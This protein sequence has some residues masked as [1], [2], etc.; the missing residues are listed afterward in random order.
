M[1][2]FDIFHASA[3]K[4]ENEQLKS[5]IAELQS[6][7]DNLK[8]NLK[9]LSDD[10]FQLKQNFDELQ[11]T[12]SGET[13]RKLQQDID[14]F[15]QQKNNALE[16]L[17]ATELLKQ[18]EKEKLQNELD[19]ISKSIIIEQEKYDKKIDSAKLKVKSINT[20][21]K[22]IQK[23]IDADRDNRY[24]TYNLV[25]EATSLVKEIDELQINSLDV[26]ALRKLISNN[27]ESVKNVIDKYEN[28][29]TTKSNKAVYQLMVLALE[30]ELQNVLLNLKLGK[31]DDAKNKIK[32]LLE[33]YYN[34]SSN[35]NQSIAPTIKKF[36]LEMETLYIEAIEIEYEYYTQKERIKEEQRAIKEQMRQEAEER[37][38]LEQQQKKL[39]KE[40]AKYK[41]EMDNV[42]LAIETA[43]TDEM[44]KLKAR[45]LELETMLNAV[46]DKKEQVINLQNGQAGNVYIISNIGSFGENVFKV[47]MT[48]RLEPQERID[49]LG[50]A[51][52]PFPF[53]VHSFIFSD[54]AVALENQLHKILDARRVNKVNKRKEFF[55]VSLKELEQLVHHIEPA[56]EFHMTALAEQ[57]TISK[58]KPDGTIDY[59]A[60]TLNNS[61]NL[62][63]PET[64]SVSDNEPNIINLLDQIKQILVNFRT[65]EEAAQDCLKIHVYQ[66]NRKIGIVKIYPDN[67]AEFKIPGQNAVKINNVEDLQKCLK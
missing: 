64:N 13:Q 2:F 61:L 63:T 1:G 35:G 22:A 58:S 40:E 32:E 48:R 44:E 66:D 39:E 23:A 34:I 42:R 46:E 41:N 19:N 26:P 16:D 28:R 43:D 18:Q 3:I 15:K 5:Q 37:K 31:I 29:Y 55:H 36:I 53:D 4:Q 38:Q 62:K 52:V 56:A 30:S 65:Q 12:I 6:Y 33:K 24:N 17:K 49:E 45:L 57:Y 20:T 47:G 60:A 7:N 11:K 9:D 10:R 27:R 14:S 21:L 25:I 59:S 67:T 8:K 51:S 54:N 50:N